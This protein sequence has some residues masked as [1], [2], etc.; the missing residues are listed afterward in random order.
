MARTP[1]VPGPVDVHGLD[2]DLLD[3]LDDNVAVL[4][5]HLGVADVR[6][7]FGCQ[8]FFDFPQ[9]AP[10]EDCT[11][12]LP[13]LRRQQLSEVLATVTGFQLATPCVA[14]G[15]EERFCAE[16]LGEGRPVIVQGDAFLM[17]W[18]PYY[19]R[20]HMNHSF[21]VEAVGDGML[22]VADAYYNKTEWGEAAP[23]RTLLPARALQPLAETARA[24]GEPPF[25]MLEP[26]GE[27]QPLD[28]AGVLR[29]NAAQIRGQLG[30]RKLMTAFSQYYAD[31]ITAPGAAERFSLAC[32]LIARDRAL[33]ARWLGDLAADQGSPVG[34][35]VAEAFAE[36]VAAPWQQALR[37]SYLLQRR[38]KAGK[39]APDSAFQQIERE[40]EPAEIQAAGLLPGRDRAGSSR[41]N[42]GRLL[43]ADS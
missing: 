43:D 4:L 9:Q 15:D 27:P 21:I 33:H 3:C 39:S 19:G 6:S 18:L 30:E 38:V 41:S 14:A 17:P 7:P 8:W 35:H 10:E 28:V 13:V 34:A 29:Q 22:D 26:V 20:Q 16:M 24:A 37:F 40:I 32:W 1:A 36:R 5:R 2:N 25:L 11:F 23:T 42:P 31:A 12:P